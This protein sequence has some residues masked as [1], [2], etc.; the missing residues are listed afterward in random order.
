MVNLQTL[1]FG[2][3]F[4]TNFE[5]LKTNFDALQMNFVAGSGEKVVEEGDRGS[6]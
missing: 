6:R 1:D 3:E 4:K 5:T 2:F